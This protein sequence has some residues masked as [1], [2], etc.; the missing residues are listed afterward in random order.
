MSGSRWIAVLVATPL[1]LAGIL[2]AAA[3][4]ESDTAWSVQRITDPDTFNWFADV[5]V[6]AY[7]APHVVWDAS[8]LD[9]EQA[10]LLLHTQRIDGAWTKPFDVVTAS[11]VDSNIWRGS[12]GADDAGFLYV[13]EQGAVAYLRKFSARPGGVS[14]F[15]RLRPI[16]LDDG[17]FYMGALLVRPGGELHV[18]YDRLTEV[19]DDD[20][21]S[22]PSLGDVY[23]MRGAKRGASW[24]KPVNLSETPVGETREKLE[25]DSRGVLY[26]SWDEGWDRPT[27]YGEPERGVLRISSDGGRSWSPK[28]HFDEPERSNAQLAVGGD[29][30]GGVLAVW[31][32]TTRNDAV[33]YSWSAD[34]GARWSAP[35]RIPGLL[36][37]LWSD[38]PFD[39]YDV[40][41]DSAG[42]I[43]LLAVGRLD[44]ETTYS[45]LYHLAWN[46]KAWSPPRR[47]N[48]SPDWPEYPRLVVS[49]GNRLHAVWFERNLLH[50]E[51][52]SHY[53]IWYATATS[54]APAVP[55]GAEPSPVSSAM[56]ANFVGGCVAVALI[57]VVVHLRRREAWRRT[58]GQS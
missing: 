53:Q 16:Y 27:W 3:P 21:K 12:V 7:G 32:P 19:V 2:R 31:R 39:A 22:P 20:P 37:R 52:A 49:Q 45:Q 41:V 38:T 43:H 8:R 35:A 1:A 14:Q 25:A 18:L 6:D 26:A 36:A 47:V 11:D 15:H 51:P 4:P 57:A 5:A 30:R 56:V 40:A 46:G 44:S 9:E 54:P 13:Q 55:L 23:Y 24:T 48:E 42:V 34:D 29:G 10:S 58:A 17:S 50:T 28:I 33:F